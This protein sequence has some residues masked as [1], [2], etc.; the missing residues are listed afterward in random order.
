MFLPR[1]TQNMSE[2]VIKFMYTVQEFFILFQEKILVIFETFLYM[3]C[4]NQ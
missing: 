1:T 3:E 2:S 4:L